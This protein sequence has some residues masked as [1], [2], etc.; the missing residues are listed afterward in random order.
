MLHEIDKLK[1]E[2]TNKN[3]EVIRE[4]KR[5]AELKTAE[6]DLKSAKRK[7]KKKREKL[8]EIISKSESEI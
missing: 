5:I 7:Y 3:I 4:E 6:N 2:I 1:D 8:E